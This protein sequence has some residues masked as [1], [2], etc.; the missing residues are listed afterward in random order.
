MEWR[1]VT[2]AHRWV[3][4]QYFEDGTI[5]LACPPLRALLELMA[6]GETEELK[7]SNPQFRAMFTRES[8]LASDWYRERLETKRQVDLKLSN[9]GIEYL[10]RFL[11]LPS[12]ADECRRLDIESR[13]QRLRT[14]AD[15][16]RDP[17]VTAGWVGTIGATRMG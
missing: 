17:A 15:A 14:T 8:V 10:N 6:R 13:L 3:A 11:S 9:R 12:Y 16:L 7:L 1:N 5:E 4:E 2:E